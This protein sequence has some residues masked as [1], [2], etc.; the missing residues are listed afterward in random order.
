MGLLEM[1][2][3]IA[4][5]LAGALA[6]EPEAWGAVVDGYGPVVWGTLR[7]F[8]SL[9]EQERRDLFQ[10]VLVVLLERGLKGFRGTTEH[11]FRAYL[12]TI[13][14][15]EA[16]SLL[17][18]H[19]RRLEMLDPLLANPEQGQGRCTTQPRRE[20]E[21]PGPAASGHAAADRRYRVPRPP[22]MAYQA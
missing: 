13:T 6:R 10:D 14:E 7:K 18:R 12:K 16:K 11:E 22:F 2:P 4:A 3:G 19:G 8:A 21:A 1:A 9:S 15:N 5:L 20:S 17:R